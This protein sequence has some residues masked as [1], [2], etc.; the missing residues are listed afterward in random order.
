MEEFLCHHQVHFFS[1]HI[2]YAFGFHVA[3]TAQLLNSLVAVYAI[4]EQ[5]SR[6]SSSVQASQEVQVAFLCPH[7]ESLVA[8]QEFLYH[9]QVSVLTAPVLQTPCKAHLYVVNQGFD[10]L[11]VVLVERAQTTSE[12]QVRVAHSK[13]HA[14][15][16]YNAQVSRE[17][18]V[19]FPCPHQESL[20]AREEFL[21]HLQVNVMTTS[22]CSFPRSPADGVCIL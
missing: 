14:E 15:S 11:H 8:L 18:Q 1:H 5:Q 7:Q 3:V 10:V 21:C 9:L 20:V 6:S 22:A 13:S 2:C 4:P 12:E 16:Q 19:A 17:V